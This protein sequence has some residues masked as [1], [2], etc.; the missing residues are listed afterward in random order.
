MGEGDPETD[1]AELMGL[2]NVHLLGP[3]PYGQLPSY[4]RG[5]DLAL[6]PCPMNAYTR[7][8]F[9]MKFFEYLAAGL[10]VVATDLPA[11]A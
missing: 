2:R 5:F 3:R 9:Q 11:L 8:M 4:L 1:L 7:S 10:P 6:L